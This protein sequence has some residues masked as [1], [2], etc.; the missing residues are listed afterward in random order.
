MCV[1]SEENSG[2]VSGCKNAGIQRGVS[3]Q[4]NKKA[5]EKWKEEISKK[6]LKSRIY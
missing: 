2:E 4:M 1:F 6:D 5:H 3:S